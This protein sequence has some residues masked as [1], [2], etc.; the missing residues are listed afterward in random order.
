MTE[1]DEYYETMIRAE[2]KPDP[3]EEIAELEKKN[4]AIYQMI[5]DAHKS[6]VAGGHEYEAKI[7]DEVHKILIDLDENPDKQ[8]C[9]MM[10]TS[11][12]TAPEFTNQAFTRFPVDDAR[13][14]HAARAGRIQEN[15]N[16]LNYFGRSMLGL[17]TI[18][19]YRNVGNQTPMAHPLSGSPLNDAAREANA[20]MER[21]CQFG[22]VGCENQA[23]VM[24]EHGTPMCNPCSERDFQARGDNFDYEILPYTPHPY[25]T[26]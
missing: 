20:R 14:I 5:R 17:P 2:K 22:A 13:Q 4:K 1:D 19:P 8:D 3:K 7:L 15:Q 18:S 26:R 25:P 9:G 10:L 16:R 24:N 12:I 11:S 6:L 23:T 21:T